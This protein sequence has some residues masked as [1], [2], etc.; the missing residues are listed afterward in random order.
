M[1]FDGCAEVLCPTMAQSLFFR[2]QGIQHVPNSIGGDHHGIAA[3]EE[4]FGSARAAGRRDCNKPS[5]KAN[6]IA[7]LSVSIP[8]AG[9]IDFRHD[10]H[11]N[12]DAH[13]GF[14]CDKS[15]TD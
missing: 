13:D 5:E 7:L 3:S 6:D 8:S 14:T 1:A 12:E 2:L 11:R 9:K 10:Q 4:P 15:S